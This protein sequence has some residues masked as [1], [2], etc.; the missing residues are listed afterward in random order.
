ML[1][2]GPPFLFFEPVDQF[3]EICMRDAIG[4]HCYRIFNFLQIVITT[5]WQVY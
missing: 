2:V 1:S 4:E 5:T 3:H